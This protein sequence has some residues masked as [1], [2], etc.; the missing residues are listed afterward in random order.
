MPPEG[1]ADYQRREYCKGIKCQVQALMDKKP[2]GSQEYNDLREICKE[3]CLHTAH[4][5]HRW[6]ADNGFLVLKP[7]K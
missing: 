2:E 3:K 1:F 5:F 6:L 4:D 7:N